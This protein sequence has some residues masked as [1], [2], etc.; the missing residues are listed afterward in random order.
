MAVAGGLPETR[1]GW[2]EKLRDGRRCGAMD[3]PVVADASGVARDRGDFAV[4]FGG[5]EWGSVAC[6]RSERLRLGCCDVRS[7][8]RGSAGGQGAAGSEVGRAGMDAARAVSGV[9]SDGEFVATDR[10]KLE[11]TKGGGSTLGAKVGVPGSR[12][13]VGGSESFSANQ[14][15]PE[16]PRLGGFFRGGSDTN[17]YNS[18]RFVSTGETFG[19]RGRTLGDFGVQCRAQTGTNGKIRGVARASEA[20]IR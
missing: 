2:R 1:G 8:R 12:L 5:T 4:S 17:T 7:S 20:Q 15:S 6:G 11:P 10:P 18:H 9:E 16:R 13:R 3:V 14:G 19:C